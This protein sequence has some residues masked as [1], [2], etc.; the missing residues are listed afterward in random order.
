MQQQRVKG[1]KK[2]IR[3]RMVKGENIENNEI[4]ASEA[5]RLSREQ[6]LAYYLKLNAVTVGYL[7]ESV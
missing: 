6:Y 1:A 7:D 4:M 5:Y 2:D 3:L